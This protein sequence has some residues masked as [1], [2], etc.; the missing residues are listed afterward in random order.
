MKR[1]YITPRAERLNFDYSKTVVAS[2]GHGDKGQK[3]G[4]DRAHGW[5]SCGEVKPENGRHCW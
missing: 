4:C 5:G 1:E 3:W 2:T